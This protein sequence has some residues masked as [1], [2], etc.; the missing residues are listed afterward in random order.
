MLVA[1]IRDVARRVA[2]M[3][4]GIHD[5]QQVIWG[6]EVRGGAADLGSGEL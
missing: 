4:W 5:E 1:V 3:I 6:S 2:P